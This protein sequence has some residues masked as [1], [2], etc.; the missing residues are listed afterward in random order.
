MCLLEATLT[1]LTACLYSNLSLRSKLSIGG[2]QILSASKLI[3]VDGKKINQKEEAGDVL[4]LETAS[5]EPRTIWNASILLG[6]R[7]S[8]K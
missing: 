8:L 4:L 7:I 3:E 2:K 1:S 6:R 5:L